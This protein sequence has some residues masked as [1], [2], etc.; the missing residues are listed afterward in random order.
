M[1]LFISHSS[2]DATMAMAIC[3]YLES[4][5]VDCWIAPRDIAPGHDYDEVI[6]DA[7]D[8][9]VAVLV[10]LSANSN[11]SRHVKH[12]IERA[13][14]VDKPIIPARLEEVEPSKKHAL[15]ISTRQMIDIDTA[16]VQSSLSSVVEAFEQLAA[17][18]DKAAPNPVTEI[19][20][21]IMREPNN[22]KPAA[23][24]SGTWTRPD[25]WELRLLLEEVCCN[26]RRFEH[27]MAL[28]LDPGAI[29]INQ[30][31][32]LSADAFADILV[33][34]PEQPPYFIEIKYGYREDEV[35]ECLVRKYGASDQFNDG[36]TTVIL[37]VD[38]QCSTAPS[39]LGQRIQAALGDR[40]NL[41]VWD[42]AALRDELARVLKIRV[43]SLAEDGV[44]QLRNALEDAKGGF[45][46]G[47]E[48]TGSLLQSNLMW[49]LGFWRIRQLRDHGEDLSTVLRAGT[50]R[51]VVVLVADL[52]CFGSYVRDTRDSEVIHAAL[53]SFYT[54]CRYEIL[55]SGG[56]LYQVAGDQVIALYGVP[57]HAEYY[58]QAALKC[59]MALSDVGDSVSSEWQQQIDRV[60]ATGGVHIGIA[61][62]DIE[63]V[64]LRPFAKNRFGLVGDCIN[65]AL[66]LRVAS[67]A[68]EAVVN[69]D[70]FRRLDPESRARFEETNALDAKN[71]GRVR[72]FKTR[73]RQTG[74]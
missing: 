29:E 4:C 7:I 27:A 62:G 59:A 48:W 37:L 60:Q 14:R 15:H 55:N 16:D 49:H 74:G 32:R 51:D 18:V 39:V 1:S 3:D 53:T 33:E 42:E 19:T 11:D 67:H 56:L 65:I 52:S 45:A 6:I 58:L 20:N 21:T 69:N 10:L 5:Q 2:E 47:D 13:V 61:L 44:E 57:D 54:K 34:V 38:Q 36:P 31:H 68:G 23:V 41:V 40:I 73:F 9:C 72:A 63:V 43:E 25:G 30:E 8:G 35:L 71:V 26:L 66:G 24:G 64:R 28:D 70:F 50:Y 17:T 46:F 22:P 12:E